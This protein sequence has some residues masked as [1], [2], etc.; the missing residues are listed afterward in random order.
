MNAIGLIDAINDLVDLNYVSS[1]RRKELVS[2][3]TYDLQMEYFTEDCDLSFLLKKA[4]SF[5][6][7]LESKGM[8]KGH[9]YSDV[10][11]LIKKFKDYG[12]KF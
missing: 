1:N 2:C 3:L 8:S 6:E 11:K 7:Y 9:L 10:L 5:K 12:F 4:V